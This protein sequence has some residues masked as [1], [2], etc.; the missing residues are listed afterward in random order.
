MNRFS[1]ILVALLISFVCIV[2]GYAA[3]AELNCSKGLEWH[4]GRDRQCSLDHQG[5]CGKRKGDWYG[6]RRAVHSAEDA[7][8][9]FVAYFA[10]Q[11]VTI[12]DINEKPWRFE[13]DVKNHSG[14]IVDRV[15]VDK[16][17]GRI[18]SIY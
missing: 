15:I 2:N 3:D 4:H 5:R 14:A 16:R 1:F 18:R 10:G 8:G 9:L 17:S 7:R 6:A 13:A 12:S 11:D